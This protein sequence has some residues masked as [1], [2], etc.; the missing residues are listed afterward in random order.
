MA[1]RSNTAPSPRR[2]IPP[3]PF[4]SLVQDLLHAVFL[5]NVLLAEKLD[6]D[7]VLGRQTL[8]VFP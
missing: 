6:L 1:C 3:R 4:T 8:G 5:A 7:A 2:Y